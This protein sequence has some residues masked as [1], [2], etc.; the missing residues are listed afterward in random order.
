M[1]KKL[2][3]GILGATGTVGQRFAELLADH[4]WFEITAL[5][6]SER[7]TGKQF[8]EACSWKLV[9]PMPEALKELTVRDLKP[10]LDCDFVFSSLPNDMAGPVEEAFALAGYPVISN[11][12]SHRLDVDV[13]LLV[14]E[15]SYAHCD[16]IPVQKARRGYDRGYIVTNPNC[17]TMAVILPLAALDRDFGV[18]GVVT[19]TLQAVSGAGYP[20][21]ASMDIVDNVVP[22][23][24][25]EEEKME[26]EARKILGR[27]QGESVEYAPFIL[28]AHCNRVNVMDGHLATVSVKLKKP[29]TREDV[30]ASMRGYVSVPQELKLPSAPV[31]P[32]VVREEIDR[33][34][35]RL[36]RE[37]E[38][39]MACVVGRVRKCPL[40]D[41]KFV[42]LGHNTIRGAAGGAILNA[43]LLRAK[44]YL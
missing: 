22:Y 32:I 14:P 2:R 28:A 6:A 38:R 7:S 19:T 42:A 30:I 25:G 23:I 43:E 26:A 33:P 24:G 9:S 34:Q 18:E 1:T 27:L 36:D 21:V 37:T 8:R 44:G 3:A 13:P 11:S 40:F 20:G 12:S 29:A 35:P 10:D 31:S 4:P 41:F 16:L 17:S 39:G 5:A 15:I